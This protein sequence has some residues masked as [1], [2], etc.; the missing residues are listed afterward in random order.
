MKIICFDCLKGVYTKTEIHELCKK[1]IG[2]FT[3]YTPQCQTHGLSGQVIKDEISSWE[4][5]DT[6]NELKAELLKI[7]FRYDPDHNR[8]SLDT[9]NID[10]SDILKTIKF[11]GYHKD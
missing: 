9:F 4:T 10:V 7:L 6:D 3:A 2:Q 8:Y 11:Y 5:I 1:Y